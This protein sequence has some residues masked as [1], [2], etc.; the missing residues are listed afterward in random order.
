MMAYTGVNSSHIRLA[1]DR[2]LVV[3]GFNQYVVL[4]RANN[5]VGS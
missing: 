5:K 2:M 3:K 4:V 1:N